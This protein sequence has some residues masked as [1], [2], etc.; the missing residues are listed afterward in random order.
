VQSVGES[1]RG[2][3]V[4]I[5]HEI[6]AVQWQRDCIA[7]SLWVHRQLQLAELLLA[8]RLPA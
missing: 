3:Q 6:W 4:L 8:N 7:F 5:K 2:I 1:V